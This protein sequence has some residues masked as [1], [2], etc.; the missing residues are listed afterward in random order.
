MF[1]RLDR[2]FLFLEEHGLKCIVFFSLASL[3]IIL[4][5]FNGSIN[6]NNFLSYFLSK[7][8]SSFISIAAIFIGV[9]FALFTIFTSVKRGSII[10]T[11]SEEDLTKLIKYLRNALIGGF[12]YII[13]T[14][15]FSSDN[16]SLIAQY[17]NI[18]LFTSLIY[19][20]LSALRF[21]GYITFIVYD[22]ISKMLTERHKIEEDA[23]RQDELLNKL[24][25]FLNEYENINR[26][27][28]T[29][30]LRKIIQ[31]QNNSP[32]S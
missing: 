12:L 11:L 28:R 16:N 3:I 32:G 9:Y 21:G 20:L 1:Q 17:F 24:E 7:K 10:S 4:N 14:L 18:I 31:N 27:E 23:S 2:F 22:D 15:F 26:E 8:E 5:W 30:I 6:I 29:K 19:M 13:L 25:V